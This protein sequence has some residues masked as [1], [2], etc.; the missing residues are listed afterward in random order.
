M[1]KSRRNGTALRDDIFAIKQERI[2]QEAV[3][4]FYENGYLPT[5]VDAIA[6]QLGATKPFVYY[7]FKRKIDLLVEICRRTMLEALE[8]TEDAA[9]LEADPIP[10]LADFVRNFTALILDRY[11]F[12]SIYFR[13]Q[14]NLPDDVNED[15]FIM[16]RKIDVALRKI[17]REGQEAGDFHFENTTI[18]SQVVAGMISYT[19][20]WYQDPGP[21]AKEAIA[22]QMLQHVL[23]SVGVAP[24][25]ADEIRDRTV[26]AGLG[27]A[28]ANLR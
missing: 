12:V 4:L 5:N 26:S 3:A 11:K 25:R 15:I 16:R 13:E 22:R 2:L 23:Q 21:I 24:A 7:H 17:L 18:A 28:A 10:K 27:P 14:L 20:A 8:V 6:Q 1:N 9:N 19:F